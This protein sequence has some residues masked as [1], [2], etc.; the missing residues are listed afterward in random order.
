MGAPFPLAKE[1]ELQ[2]AADVDAFH[3]LLLY[4]CELMLPMTTNES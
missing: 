1:G 4:V 3:I 2:P